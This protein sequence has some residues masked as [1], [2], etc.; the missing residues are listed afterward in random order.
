M[1][2]KQKGSLKGLVMNNWFVNY[3]SMIHFLFGTKICE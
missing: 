1:N 2:A 3:N